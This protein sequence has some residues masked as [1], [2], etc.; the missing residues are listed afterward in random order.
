[1]AS[2]VIY[3][4][5]FHNKKNSKAYLKYLDEV[6]KIISD[7]GKNLININKLVNLPKQIKELKRYN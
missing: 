2:N 1:M 4:S 3:L 7:C 6:F 5:V